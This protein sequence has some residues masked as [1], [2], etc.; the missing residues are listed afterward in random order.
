[1]LVFV[2]EGTE[3]TPEARKYFPTLRRTTYG[4][5]TVVTSA[6]V[7]AMINLITR[8]AGGTRRTSRC[9][10]TRRRRWRG[11]TRSGRERAE[12]ARVLRDHRPSRWARWTM[13]ASRV[14]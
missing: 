3:Y 12:L 7:R 6:I 11:S 5:A 4:M 9:S 14:R 10:P 8:F 1:V 2:A 13:R